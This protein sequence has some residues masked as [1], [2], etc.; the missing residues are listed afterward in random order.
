MVELEVK[1]GD[2]LC[3]IFEVRVTDRVMVWIG[4]G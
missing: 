4:L 1:G 3:V 2:V